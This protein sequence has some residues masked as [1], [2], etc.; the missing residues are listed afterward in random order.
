MAS[1]RRVR[2]NTAHVKVAY[3]IEETLTVPFTFSLC[4]GNNI[5]AEYMTGESKQVPS[6]LLL[7]FKTQNIKERQHS[8]PAH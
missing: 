1:V 7:C 5:T 8:A 4:R 3:S 6:R 2:N